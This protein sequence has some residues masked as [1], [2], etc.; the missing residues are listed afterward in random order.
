MAFRGLTEKDNKFRGIFTKL[1]KSF[2]NSDFFKC[3]FNEDFF[4]NRE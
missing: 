2:K 4:H 1:K 3:N